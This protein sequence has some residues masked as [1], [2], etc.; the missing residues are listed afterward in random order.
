MTISDQT[1][2]PPSAE[3]KQSDVIAEVNAPE[4]TLFVSL[5]VEKKLNDYVRKPEWSNERNTAIGLR[6]E[7]YSRKNWNNLY[8]LHDFSCFAGWE[9]CRWYNCLQ[10]ENHEKTNQLF[11]CKHGHVRSAVSDFLDS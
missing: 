6:L 4:K 2:I 1:F 8:L 3:H 10:D 11:Y 5:R 9:H 7:S